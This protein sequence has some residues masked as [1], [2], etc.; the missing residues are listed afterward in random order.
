MNSD[1]KNRIKIEKYFREAFS[2]VA[3]KFNATL[4]SSVEEIVFCSNTELATNIA[5][6]FNN[7]SIQF[8][9]K[10]YYV[11][12]KKFDK[13]QSII[14]YT[15]SNTFSQNRVFY[16]SSEHNN[17]F[18]TEGYEFD[19]LIINIK[20]VVN[21]KIVDYINSFCANNFDLVKQISNSKYE[22]QNCTSKIAI[23]RKAFD[24]T[25][26]KC[27]IHIEMNNA[28]IFFEEKN[29]RIIRKLLQIASNDICM[30]VS[31][32]S[33]GID[34]KFIV[35]G[36]ASVHDLKDNG[37]QIEILGP[38]DIK[39]K[40]K[41][42][43]DLKY[44]NE[45]FLSPYNSILS[46]ADEERIIEYFSNNNLATA[47]IAFI[48]ELR[49]SK[50]FFHGAIVIF[51]DD[52]EFITHEQEH[53]RAVSF[54]ES[55][56]INLLQLYKDESEHTEEIKNLRNLLLNLCKIDGAIIFNIE[57]D[58]CLF[59]AILDGVSQSPGKLERGSRFNS[60]KT[61]VEHY[62]VANKDNNKNYL[63]IVMSE[64]GPVNVFSSKDLKDK[65]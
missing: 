38:Y 9:S 51:T 16:L 36:F 44:V 40:E 12:F 61:F 47:T 11:Y 37:M 32:D 8:E 45:R 62:Y 50:E 49:D 39:I 4:P 3:Q 55:N 13:I 5:N 23:F 48:N 22:N 35:R 41:N 60:T 65:V 42:L 6:S 63:A 54:S 56:R 64:D 28:S 59:G 25:L 2:S 33:E 29:I 1:D 19:K 34:N 52:E 24:E 10:Y 27:L 7:T 17:E 20:N 53:N 21:E 43:F 31:P 26:E 18:S 57:G 46:R 58:L 14:L 15:I 30:I